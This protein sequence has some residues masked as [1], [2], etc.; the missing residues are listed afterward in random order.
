MSK[1]P[2][3]DARKVPVYCYQCVAGPDLMKVHVENGVATRVES[4]WDI[5][6]Q[7]PGGGRVCVKAYGLI[8]KTYNPN[9]IKQP[10]KRTNPR[11]GRD[12]D[13]GF[14]PISWDEAFD[15]VGAKLRDIR[16]K[17]LIDENG[18]PR[19]ATSTGGG[20]TPVQY[21]GTFPAFMAAWGPIDQGYGAGQGV[22]CYHSEH[23][24]GEFWHRAFIVSPD[25]PYV[26]YIVNCGNNVEASGGV[27]GIWR[28]ADARV[29][30]AKRVQVEPHLSIT[31]AVSAEW[32]PIKPKTD[33][34]F[35]FGLIHRIVHERGWK[36]VC[37]VPFLERRTNS[38]YLVGPN[39][40]FLRD[41][42]SEKPLVW[43]LA[44]GRAKAYDD[45]GV[46]QPALDGAYT[47]PAGVEHGPDNARFVHQNVSAA[48]SFQRFLDHMKPYTPDWAAA[49][50]DV[51]AETIRRVADEF[52][53]HACIGETIE[54]EGRRLPFR[55]VAVM[56]GKGISNGWGAYHCCWAQK[57]LAVLMGALEVPGGTL[58]TAV[59]LVRPAVSRTG[60]VL[61]GPD[62]FMQYQ[63][64]ETSANGWMRSPHIRNAYKT[65]VPL[66]SD[67][68]WSP[69]LG[70]AHLP[71]LF[72]KEQ[73][74]AWPRQ[75]VPD[76]WICYR[77][78]PA[79]SSWNAPEVANQLAKFPFIVAF[80]YTE[81]ETNHFA[82]ILL[83]DATDLES[84]QLIRI[85]S[86]K[87]TEQFWKHEGWAIRQPAVTPHVD[88]RDLTDI[89]TE[90]ARQAGIL[91]EYVEA[92][93]R[94]AAGMALKDRKGA[95]DYALDP[96]RP[97]TR[98][99][100]WDAVCKAASHE[101]T[102]GEQVRDLGWFAEH[103]FMLRP[104]PQID[105]YLYPALERQNLRFELPYQERLTRH[106]HELSHRLKEIGVN[107]WQD[108]L[109]EYETL[110]TY[111]RFPDIWI[112][113]AREYGR[114]PGDYPFWALTARSMQYSWGANVG[115]PII[116]EV[117]DNIAGHKGV[118]INRTTARRLGIKEGDRV[119]IESV[120][121]TTE[122]AAVLREGIRPDTVVMIGQFDHWKTPFAKDLKRPSLN[123]VTDLSLKLTDG[124]GSGADLMR[125]KI[126]RL[127]AGAAA[128]PAQAAA[129]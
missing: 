77:T 64:N 102:N 89:A 18:F 58:G 124:T 39:G 66:V 6:G 11:K 2:A 114:D 83:P 73:P 101:L 62:G 113:Y 125:V 35:L 63:F 108:Q 60:S 72:L 8:Q 9:R 86:T 122:G 116:A 65:L 7:H 76:M 25:T 109:R 5:S 17:G 59:K 98:E 123:S 50:C 27:V 53:A 12:Q 80:A 1:P 115:L 4:N 94:G 43:D 48:P 111:E 118:I 104:F 31:G 20:G 119:R 40:W 15:I 37:D 79:I 69:A 22:K 28:E 117:A 121:G 128:P 81:D 21:M 52:V 95:F 68:P 105:W 14:V 24:Y 56:L 26:N 30:G 127:G 71:W 23:L 74:E 75:S 103:G 61:P 44:D 70:P 106:G 92:V 29:R 38:P 93:N 3:S 36:S 78:N 46:K 34:A 47:V 45:P 10:M 41:P 96:A 126:V 129:E 49:E 32:V 84:L 88:V 87:F 90:F 112:E 13:P 120:S 91:K 33:A 100:V 19:L 42:A 54:I 51:T 97:P 55:P 16:A 107:W 67:S 99:E 110:P 57:M 85:G 82:D